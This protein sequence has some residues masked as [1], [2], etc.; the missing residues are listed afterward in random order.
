MRIATLTLNP[1]L[2]IHSTA[3]EVRPTRKIRTTDEH[4]DPGGGGINVARVIH[5]L[6]GDVIAVVLVGGTTGLLLEE[7]LT[8]TGIWGG[9]APIRGRTRMSLNVLEQHTGLEYR[10]VPEGPVVEPDEW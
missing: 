6:G 9:G 8:E 7:L 2:D 1:A 10:F 3:P 4:V 5:A